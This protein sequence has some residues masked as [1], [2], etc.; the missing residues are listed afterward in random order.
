MAHVA[1]CRVVETNLI[2]DEVAERLISLKRGTHRPMNLHMDG[3][4]W[5]GVR[6]F[7]AYSLAT[8]VPVV[9][10]GVLL[11]HTISVE[12]DRSALDDGSAQA[13]LIAQSAIQP[14]LSGKPLAAGVTDTEREQLMRS[15]SGL[16]AQ[17]SVLRLRLRDVD[18]RVMFNAADPTAP[19]AATTE[20]DEDVQHA[21]EHGETVKVTTVDSD[22]VDGGAVG[23]TSAVEAYVPLRASLHDPTITGVVE[24]YVPYAP[25]AAG[26]QASLQHMQ[27]II[28]LGLAMLWCVLAVIVVSVTVRVRRHSRRTEYMALHDP[29]TGLPN[30]TLYAD[31]VTAALAAAGRTG[32]DVA[33]AVVDLDRFKEVNDTLGH[34]NGDEF[35]RIVA[36]RLSAALRPGDTVARLGGDEFGIVLP[37]A[38]AE[39]VEQVLRRLQDALGQEAELAG[40]AVSAEASVG[41]AIWPADADTAEALVQRADL[42]LY[43]AKSARAT[44]VRYHP[45]V[46]EFDPQR[47]GLIAEL[48]RAITG[49]DLVLHY[50]PKV[51]VPTGRVIGFEALV[52]WMHPVRGLVAPSDFIPVA[53]S[54]GLIL[55]LTQW[56][57]DR[58]L[59]Q[60]AEWSPTHPDLCIAVNISARNLRDDLPGWIL[61]RLAAHRVKATRLVLEITETSFA[62]DPVRATGLLEELDAAGVRVSLDDFGQ[63]YTSLG[64]LGHLPVSE[65]K[66][67]R[68]FVVAMQQNPEDRAIVASVIELGH[69]LGLIVVAEGVETE[70]VCADLRLLGCDTMQGYLFSP[71]VP[72]DEVLALLATTH[73]MA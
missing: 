66:I 57:V 41:Y 23:G 22:A 10:L 24:L 3:M 25:I 48:R 31:R 4:A 7:V 68:G 36:Q 67:D 40:V 5:R 45:G 70:E 6:R 28:G 35:L 62:T 14:F 44:I 33:L 46:D 65:L 58:A 54:T 13:T 38:R 9:W 42:A 73:A 56:V 49:G 20:A 17:G 50:Q 16:L 32:T 59:A 12:S 71:P 21:V 8:L 27:M 69:Q 1:D 11:A 15:T 64:S 51:D 2:S 55:P 43:A 26:R 34:R 29:L 72:A 52:R 61:N 18:G 19:A 53:E 47:L 63:G 60:L 39:S 37:G 30:R